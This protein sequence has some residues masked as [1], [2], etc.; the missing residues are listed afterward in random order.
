[1]NVELK[2]IK[3]KDGAGTE[4]NVHFYKICFFD[5]AE[6]ENLI[7]EEISEIIGKGKRYDLSIA[8]KR[9]LRYL[10][11]LPIKA[12]IGAIAEFFT[13]LFL[14]TKRVQ[15]SSFLNLEGKEIKKG[16][17]GLYKGPNKFWLMESKSTT[18]T[19][20]QHYSKIQ[21]ALD[22]LRD[23]VTGQGKYLNNPWE[24]AVNHIASF[25]SLGYFGS[26]K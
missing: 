2:R 8:K 18:E 6:L 12:K 14:R 1:M 7:D 17:D 10:N 19:S 25:E 11:S 13:H 20:V 26:M 5:E 15:A 16:F 3:C 9:V 21:E 22:D 24:N 4:K 23:K